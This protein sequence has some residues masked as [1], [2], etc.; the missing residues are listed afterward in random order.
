[1]S[2]RIAI[3]CEQKNLQSW[4]IKLGILGFMSLSFVKAAVHRG[5]NFVQRERL[6]KICLKQKTS[7]ATKNATFKIDR[8]T[9]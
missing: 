7:F 5:R 1:M 6:K 2:R 4:E 9:K 8:H 3:L